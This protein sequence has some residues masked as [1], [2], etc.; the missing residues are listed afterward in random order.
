M[1]SPMA[2]D[3]PF[4]RLARLTASTLLARAGRA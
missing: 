1:L 3:E 4:D 2:G